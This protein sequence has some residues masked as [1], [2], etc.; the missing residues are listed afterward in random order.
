MYE[1]HLMEWDLSPIKIG[2]CSHNI[3][4]TIVPVYLTGCCCRFHGLSM[5][6]IGDYFSPLVVPSG[7]MNDSW[8]SLQL[9]HVQ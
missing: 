7:T 3:C 1:L 5:G 6:D 8:A 2:D 4:D 9:I